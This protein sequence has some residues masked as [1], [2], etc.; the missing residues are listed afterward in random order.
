M[1][2]P[3]HNVRSRIRIRELVHAHR[4]APRACPTYPAVWGAVAS[5]FWADDMGR[6]LAENRRVR[7]AAARL[8]GGGRQITR[9]LQI[10]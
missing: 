1:L 10:G 9:V 3:L 6:V 7:R 5:T 8:A 4:T 2:A